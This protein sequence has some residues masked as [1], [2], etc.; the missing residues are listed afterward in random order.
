MIVRAMI[1][2]F[3]DVAR[4]TMIAPITEKTESN[5]SVMRAP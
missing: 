5:V 3:A 4:E 2:S 1:S